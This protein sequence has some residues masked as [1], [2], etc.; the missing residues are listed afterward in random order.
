MGEK[1]HGTASMEGEGAAATERTSNLNLSKSN[2]DRITGDPDFDTARAS[3]VKSSKSNSSD[4]E[5]VP[6]GSAGA[7]IAIDEPGVQ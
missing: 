7:G 2:I 1:E 4:R 6:G 5:G 3:S